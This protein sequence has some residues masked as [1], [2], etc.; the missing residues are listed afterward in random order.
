VKGKA[1]QVFLVHGEG[2]PAAILSDKLVEA[3]MDRPAFPQLRES[4]EI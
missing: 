2:T 3:G 1:K 4:V